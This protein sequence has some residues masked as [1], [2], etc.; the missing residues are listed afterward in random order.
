MEQL[1]EYLKG[2]IFEY[3]LTDDMVVSLDLQ[4][5]K[6]QFIDFHNF[7]ENENQ[8]NQE[9]MFYSGSR[10]ALGTKRKCSYDNF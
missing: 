7:K 3:D 6:A 8:K 5:R 1:C 4:K 2:Q 9:Q 10:V